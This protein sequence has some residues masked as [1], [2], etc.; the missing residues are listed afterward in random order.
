MKLKFKKDKNE[1]VWWTNMVGLPEVEPVQ[2]S[3]NFIPDWFIKTHKKIPNTHPKADVGTIKNCPAMPDFFKL[4]Y[5]VPL[6]C[7]LIVNVENDGKYH[8][9]SSNKEFKWQIHGDVQYKHHLPDNAQ[10]NCALVVKPD[11]PWYVKT[12]PGV[13][14][15]QMPLFYH[16]NPDFTVLPGTIWTDIHHEINQ[17]MVLHNYG[18]TFITKGTPLAMYIPIRRET[19]DYTVRHQTPEDH[20]NFMISALKTASKFHRGYKMSQLARKKLD[21]S[22]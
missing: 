7:D 2:L 15:L 19:F 8:W 3:Q 16:F 11:C 1:I 10:E 6:W 13:S 22:E 5:V 14:L 12:P 4:G 20:E 17:Q 9:K 18:E 21:N